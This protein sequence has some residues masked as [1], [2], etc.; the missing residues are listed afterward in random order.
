MSDLMED[1][2]VCF[3]DSDSGT[4]CGN[5][6]TEAGEQCDCGDMCDS[7]P[8]CA[9]NCTLTSGSSCRLGQIEVKFVV[10]CVCCMKGYMVFIN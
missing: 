4:F 3:L 10:D 9:V 1:V 6:V 5:G 8:C 7:D 2:L